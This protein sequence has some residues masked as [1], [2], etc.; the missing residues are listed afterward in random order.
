MIGMSLADRA[1]QAEVTQFSLTL[2]MNQPANY[3]CWTVIIAEDN[4]ICINQLY[5]D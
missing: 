4:L 5:V 3:Q 2:I 1:G